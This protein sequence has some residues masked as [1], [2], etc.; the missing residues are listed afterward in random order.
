MENQMNEIQKQFQKAE[1]N[2]ERLNNLKSN[3]LTL[4]KETQMKITKV[5]LTLTKDET[6][7]MAF[8]SI[9]YNR[10]FVVAGVTVYK[11][12]DG[13]FFVKLPQ[14]KTS[15]GESKDQCF[16]V[17]KDLR[18]ELNRAVLDEFARKAAA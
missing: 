5:N 4:Q 11:N 7:R 14:Y 2:V 8:G 17:T 18:K 16:P 6:N 1:K 10:C 3:S 13:I 15:K 12:R 9:T